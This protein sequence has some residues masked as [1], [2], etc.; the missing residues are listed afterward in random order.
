MVSGAPAV[1][2]VTVNYCPFSSVECKI[3]DLM[4]LL[5]LSVF[6]E[7]SSG[8]PHHCMFNL[9]SVLSHLLTASLHFPSVPALTHFPFSC[10]QGEKR[11]CGAGRRL[12]S[13]EKKIRHQ[14]IPHVFQHRVLFLFYAAQIRRLTAA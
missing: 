10:Y 13:W 8:V 14:N 3:S 11:K 5:S 7:G 9:S 2:N 12:E 1:L 6:L 4:H